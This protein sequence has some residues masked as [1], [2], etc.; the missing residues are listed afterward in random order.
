MGSC[1]SQPNPLNNHHHKATT[2][3]NNNDDYQ[4]ADPDLTNMIGR[5]L[6]SM[7]ETMTQI[8]KFVDHMN[9]QINQACEKFEELKTREGGS[10]TNELDQLK[11]S[12]NKL[13]SQIPSKLKIHYDDDSKPH[14][15]PWFDD[16]SINSSSGNYQ[17]DVNKAGN[18]HSLYNQPKFDHTPALADILVSFHSLPPELQY[19]LNFFMIFPEM[20]TMKKRFLIDWWMGE[21]VLFQEP[22]DI[23][24]HLANK[25]LDEFTAKGFIEPIYKNCGLVVDSYRMPPYIRSALTFELEGHAFDYFPDIRFTCSERCIVNIDA[26]IID[27]RHEIIFKSGTDV[28]VVCLGRWQNSVTHHIEVP[29]IKILNALKNMKQLSFL[30]LRGISMITELPQFISQLTHLKILDLKACH[31]LVVVPDWIG[32]LENLRQLDISECYLLDHMPKG[33]GT[34]YNLQVLKG[35]II[36]DSRDKKSCTFDDLTK[37]PWLR[38]LSISTSM[39]EFPTDLQLHHLQRL[40]FLR[41]LKISWSGC[42]LQGKTNDSPKRAQLFSKRTTLTRSSTEQHDPELSPSLELPSLEKLELHCFPETDTPSWLWSG[43]LK[44]L[45]KLYIK[46]G[47]LR[48]LNKIVATGVEMLQLKYLSDFQMHGIEDLRRL[49]PKLIYFEKVECPGLKSFPSE[50]CL[51]EEMQNR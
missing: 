29:D 33:L 26:A 12:V 15:K 47:L 1:I 18:L 8:Q 27:G 31:N 37:L 50:W 51:D 21:R 32:L 19:F 43:N 34:L 6:N 13:K 48:N 30:S 35:F 7:K 2:A 9:V 25:I 3:T 11:M 36:G 24:K 20:A 14:R 10:D 22:A 39:K 16:G 42:I 17:V 41:Q 49:F 40:K 28:T 45:K 23:D 5:D 44:N 46:G 4:V 38:K